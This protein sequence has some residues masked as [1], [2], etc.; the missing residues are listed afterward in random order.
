MEMDTGVGLGLHGVHTS[1]T[2]GGGCPPV[3]IEELR[4]QSWGAAPSVQASLFPACA[5]TCGLALSLV[6]PSQ[7][8]ERWREAL[9][10]SPS[11][12]KGSPLP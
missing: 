1:P 2:P 3:A 7:L 12:P 11:L 4:P 10:S 5:P 6:C 9:P 8:Q